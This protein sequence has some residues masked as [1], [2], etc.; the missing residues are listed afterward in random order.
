MGIKIEK[1]NRIE[2]PEIDRDIYEQ[3]ISLAK[4]QRQL[5]EQ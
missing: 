5:C 1:V 4:M 2:S 3:L